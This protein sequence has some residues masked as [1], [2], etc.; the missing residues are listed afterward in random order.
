MAGIYQQIWNADQAQNGIEA[1][2]DTQEGSLD[3]G[4][5]K[6]NAELDENHDPDLKVLTQVHIPQAKEET[7]NLCKK[8]FNNYTLA[9]PMPEFDTPEERQEVHDFVSAIIETEPMAVARHYI[10]CETGSSITRERWHN[11][12][13]EMWFRRFSS[14]GDPALSGFE[15]VIVGEQEKSKVQGYH[16]WWKYYLDDG[17]GH[18]VDDGVYNFPGLVADRITYH[19]SKQKEG[20]LKYPESVTISYRWQ[21]PDYENEAIRPLFKKIGGFFV[22]CSVE[23]LMALGTVRAHKGIRAPKIAVIEGARYEMKLYHSPNGQHIR[24][25]YPVFLGDADVTDGVGRESA[26]GGSAS[27]DCSDV[28]PAA[29]ANPVRIIAAMVNPKDDD[30]GFE[31]VTLVNTGHDRAAIDGWRLSDKN[32]KVHRIVDVTLNPGEFLTISLTGET[33]QLSNQG[34]E[35]ILKDANRIIVHRVTYSR[36]QA[37]QQGV[38]ILF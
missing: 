24:T 38:T 22:G 36:N 3:R 13:V 12:I 1:I 14:G 34:G 29:N 18:E 15:H 7:Y 35:I 4:Y 26:W 16:F 5:V 27:T 21:A 33:T 17:F 20:Q 31:N 11:T 37:S 30:V 10:A 6:V 8:L 28:H 2:L 9:E 25:F 19:G 32:N 23:G